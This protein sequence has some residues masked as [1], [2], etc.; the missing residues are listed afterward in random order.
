MSTFNNDLELQRQEVARRRDRNIHQ[1][2]SLVPAPLIHCFSLFSN[3]L[4]VVHCLCAAIFL[5][6][7]AGAHA[8]G[9]KIIST[10]SHQS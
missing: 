9:G 8:D 1:I 7:A 2:A 5:V 6:A 3:P 4:R 10:Y